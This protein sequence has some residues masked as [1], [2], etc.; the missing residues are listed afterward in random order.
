MKGLMTEEK[1]VLESSLMLWDQDPTLWN[2]KPVLQISFM[3]L[4]D[5]GEHVMFVEDN[6]IQALNKF[7]TVG[8]RARSGIGVIQV[9]GP[10]S[11]RPSA[12]DVIF[13]GAVDLEEV[14]GAFDLFLES[15]KIETIIMNFSSPGGDAMGVPELAQK[16]FEGREKKK[17]IS[18]ADP[19]SCS[20]SFWLSSA[21]SESYASYNSGIVG[22]VG[23]FIMHME[24]SK[25]FEK[26]GIK[27]TIIRSTERKAESNPYEAL[28]DSAKSELQETVTQLH[29]EFESALALFRGVSIDHVSEKFGK[30]RGIRADKAVSA[31]MIDGVMS[32]SDLINREAGTLREKKKQDS[33]RVYFTNQKQY[34]SLLNLKK[35]G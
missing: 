24:Y 33:R 8:T 5:S 3:D 23:A 26:A 4:F 9:S 29:N 13:N 1:T 32:Y 15:D 18:I 27:P 34:L 28:S 21:A 19:F 11:F 2:E 35:R 6:K 7:L 25:Y 17:I 31:K 20:A 12:W 30:G 14:E 10:I 22:S 16:I